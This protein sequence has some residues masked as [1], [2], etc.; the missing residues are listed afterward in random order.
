MDL[1][2]KKAKC[3]SSAC[4]STASLT[5]G[6]GREYLQRRT[7][8]D[9]STRVTEENGEL[10]SEHLDIEIKLNMYVK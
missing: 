8:K 10:R 2:N 1:K 7:E 3:P 4:L 9:F 6:G 5:A